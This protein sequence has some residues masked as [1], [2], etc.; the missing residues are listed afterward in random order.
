M[1]KTP[2]FAA[3]TYAAPAC[4]ELATRLEGI[5]CLSSG[6]AETQEFGETDISGLF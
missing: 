4:T 2:I 1:R 6:N 5:L 3:N